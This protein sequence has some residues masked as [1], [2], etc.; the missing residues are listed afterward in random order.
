[1]RTG[2]PSAAGRWLWG[3]TCREVVEASPG[4]GWR[5][6][7]GAAIHRLLCSDCR[8]YAQQLAL[9]VATLR[10]L[11]TPPAPERGPEAGARS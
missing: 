5:L 4:A 9:T 8:R 11:P 7:L 6:R 2:H 3:L 10:R 1:M